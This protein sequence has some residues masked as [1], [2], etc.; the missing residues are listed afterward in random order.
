MS[1]ILTLNKISKIGL[2]K[3]SSEYKISDN[4]ENPDAILLRSFNMHEYDIPKSVLAIGR[5]GAGVRFQ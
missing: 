5:A 1:N 4:V 3:F 2:S